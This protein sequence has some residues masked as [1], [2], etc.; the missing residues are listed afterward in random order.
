MRTSLGRHPDYEIEAAATHPEARPA[1]ITGVQ[2]N[3]TRSNTH[4]VLI[5]SY[6]PGQKGARYG[7]GRFPV[8]PASVRQTVLRPADGPDQSRPRTESGRF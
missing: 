2:A 5:P 8:G 4:L 3:V 1:A 6:N 7:A